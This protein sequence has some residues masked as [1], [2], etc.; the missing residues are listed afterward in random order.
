M[1]I[2][3]LSVIEKI[4][5]TL[6]DKKTSS[7]NQCLK[8]FLNYE[9]FVSS[10]KVF[11]ISPYERNTIQTLFKLF[12]KLIRYELVQGS[13]NLSSSNGL[14]MVLVRDLEEGGSTL[15]ILIGI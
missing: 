13:Q 12:D 5:I 7:S 1:N 15:P 3:S 2:A 10:V 9:N 6:F 4:T 8:T 11:I 14:M